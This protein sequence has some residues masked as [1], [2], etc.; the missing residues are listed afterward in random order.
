MYRLFY[1]DINIL[2]C[3]SALHTCIAIGDSLPF[4][5]KRT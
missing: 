2:P 3:E 4:R 1:Q 5:E